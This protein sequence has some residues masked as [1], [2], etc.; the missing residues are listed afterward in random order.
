MF[1]LSL[2]RVLFGEFLHIFGMLIFRR[3]AGFSE[4]SLP[5]QIEGLTALS[6]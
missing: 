2:A 5:C 6:G 4:G 1:A 3:I